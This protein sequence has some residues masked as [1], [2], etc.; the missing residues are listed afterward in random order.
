MFA[1]FG[2][3]SQGISAAGADVILAANHNPHAVEVHATNFPDTEHVLADLVN[4]EAGVGYTDPATF[5]KADALWASPSCKHHSPANAK[6]LYKE[7]AATPE[8]QLALFGDGN[9]RYAGSERSRITMSCVLRYAAKHHPRSIMVENVVEAA[10]WGPNRDGSTFRWWLDELHNLGYETKPL[11]LNSMF[12][13]PCPQS[14]DRMYVVAWKKGDTPPDLDYRPAAFCVSDECGG[15]DVEAVQTFKK[16]TKAWPIPN[17]GKYGAQYIYCCPDCGHEVHPASFPAYSAI[18]W[19]NLGPS[20]GEREK[21]LAPKTMDRIKRAFLKFG[22][23]PSVALPAGLH[24]AALVKQFGNTFE[25]PGQLRAR[26]VDGRMPTMTTSS[27]WSLA[28]KAHAAVVEMRGGGSVKAGQHPVI[29]P[30]H[31]VTAGGNHHGL[32]MSVNHGGED[33]RHRPLTSALP[34]STTKNG[35]SLVSA[36][37]TKVNGGPTDTA[38]HGVDDPFQ[39]VTTRDT[40]ALVMWPQVDVYQDEDLV[41]STRSLAR[42]RAEQAVVAKESRPFSAKVED[43]NWD[44]IDLNEVRFRML[45]PDYELRR[46]M[47][48][49]E[50]YILLGTKTQRTAGLGDA[51]T[52]PVADWITSRVVGAL[53][54]G[55]EV[56]IAAQREINRQRAAE[57]RGAFAA[58]MEPTKDRSASESLALF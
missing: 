1:G 46:T 18:D 9:E 14:R 27:E 56:D 10:K 16:Q 36:A 57:R 49:D 52:P 55:T 43:I 12:F 24:D 37:F 38:W 33:G 45:E 44:E 40:T 23:F 48:F 34:T 21:P 6:K 39:T 28:T 41:T 30:L 8:A 25:R 32:V 26:A 3:A 42:L 17:W 13:P 2:G 22:G 31:T 50:N 35:L 11:M 53:T 51:V 58:L 29:D 15:V 4:P 19:T 20:L 54:S 47:A 7:G 5:P